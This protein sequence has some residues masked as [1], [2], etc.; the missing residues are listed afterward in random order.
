MPQVVQLRWNTQVTSD[1]YVS[2]QLWLEASLPTC[3]FHRKGGC[4]FGPLGTY[5]RVEPPGTLIPRWYCPEAHTTVSLLPDCFASRLSGTLDQLEEAVAHVETAPSVDIAARELRPPAEVEL[6]GALRWTRRRCRLVYTTL[7]I[8]ITLLPELLAGCTPTI[9][10]VRSALGVDTGALVRMRELCAVHLVSLPPPV[11]F[12]PRT[13]AAVRGKT[14]RPHE[15]GP[16]P[17]SAET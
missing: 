11:G 2:R 9:T 12:G 1:E 17:P 4:G 16:A 13:R 15:A 6:P 14:P 8:V 7:T 5:E 10:A 3:P